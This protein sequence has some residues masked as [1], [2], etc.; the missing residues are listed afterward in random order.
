MLGPGFAPHSAIFGR[1][2]KKVDF[3]RE[4][5]VTRAKTRRTTPNF[6]P[7]KTRDHGPP[8]FCW[9]RLEIGARVFGTGPD[10]RQKKAFFFFFFK[11]N[12]YF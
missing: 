7:V 3:W 6:F 11:K 10:Y 1:F 4:K 9:L 2:L 8:N 5:N 12:G